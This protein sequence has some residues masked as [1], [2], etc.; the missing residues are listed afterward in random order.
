[1]TVGRVS[2]RGA[3]AP[4]LMLPPG[5]PRG[6]IADPRRPHPDAIQ[7]LPR[8]RLPAAGPLPP[9]RRPDQR[10]RYNARLAVRTRGHVDCARRPLRARDATC[11]TAGSPP[12]HRRRLVTAAVMAGGTSRRPGGPSLNDPRSADPNHW[13]TPIGGTPVSQF[14][15]CFPGGN[16]NVK[17]A[18][19]R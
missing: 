12:R 15:V 6:S 18:P 10:T 5:P 13:P 19:R 9:R 14:Y 4:L 11:L 16:E 1:M 7:P 3:T 2:L 17:R 8:T